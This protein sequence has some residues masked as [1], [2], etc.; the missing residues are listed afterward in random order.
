MVASRERRLARERLNHKVGLPI[1]VRLPR[2][3]QGQS[4]RERNDDA[5]SLTNIAV[6]RKVEISAGTGNDDLALV[7]LAAQELFAAMGSGN[8]DVTASS[9]VSLT[10]R[11]RIEG[12]SGIDSLTGDASITAAL[13]QYLG[14]ESVS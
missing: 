12:G 5:P 9:L 8:D 6:T 10:Q 2:K 1:K 4:G 13:K 11:A 7:N 3:L 14:L